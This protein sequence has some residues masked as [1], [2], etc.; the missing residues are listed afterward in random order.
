MINFVELPRDVLAQVLQNAFTFFEELTPNYSE[1]K[2]LIDKAIA[3]IDANLNARCREDSC[4]ISL[5]DF[6]IALNAHTLDFVSREFLYLLV[7]ILSFG[8]PQ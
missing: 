1:V 7:G 8:T 6:T 3:V 2:E 4:E 5:T